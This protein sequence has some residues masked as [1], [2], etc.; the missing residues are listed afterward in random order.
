[1]TPMARLG[2]SGAGGAYPSAMVGPAARVEAAPYML[3]PQR[4]GDRPFRGASQPGQRQ[5]LRL[6]VLLATIVAMVL[7][8]S[9]LGLVSGARAQ[10]EEPAPKRAVV[11]SGPVHSATFRYRQYAAAIADAAEAEGMD[12]HRVFYPNATPSR[13]KRLANGA[14]LFV[15]VGHGNGWPSPYPPFQEATKNGLGLNPEDRDKRTTSKVVYKGAD[16]LKANI[17][18]AP[19]AVV[20]LSHL[21][22]ASG[23]ASSGMAIPS[24]SVAVERVD[25]FAN[26]FLASGARV[27]WALGWQPGADVVRALAREDATMN[28][29]F[30]TRYR[31]GVNPLN[32]WVG[33]APGFYASRRTPGATVHIDPDPAYG[34]LRGLTGDLEFTTREW[35]NAAEAPP[36]DT[37]PP[38][39]RDVGAAQAPVTLA[40][41]DAEPP[42]FT[43]NGDRLS[44]TIAI[45]HRLS[46]NAFV[47]LRISRGDTTVR[48][49]TLWSLKGPG[50]ITWDGR[51]NNGDYVNEG[52]FTVTMTP[53]DRAGNVG[54]PASTQ[55][56]VLN[57]LKAPAAVPPL[58]HAS[59]GDALAPRSVLRAKLTRP[60]TVTWVVRD[61]SGTVVRSGL[62]G[63]EMDA[64]T[65]RFAWDGTDDAGEQLP[66]G[67]YRGRV[68]IVRP[69]GSYG[70][71][72]IVRKMPFWF[73]PS[74]WTLRRGETLSVVVDSAEAVDGRPAISVRAPGRDWV[75]L[76][77]RRVDDDTF[78]SQVKTRKAW[79]PGQLRVR[80]EATDSGGG[81]QATRYVLK[82]R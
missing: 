7:G 23:N 16:W 11:V 62:D 48:R 52:R 28:A 43:P 59:D 58:F 72:V 45:S 14:D 78:R 38:V 73:K 69:Q 80:V 79:R 12:V 20:I 31:S 60:A 63:V 6:A 49:R 67:V 36:P 39:I 15:Y 33:A 21:S 26:G 8:G 68:R 19:N 29:V 34:Y 35:R 81:T 55:V 4:P 61:A 13:V 76:K 42:V 22:Y 64:G 74:R 77:V 9:A 10:D 18:F 65:V 17:R 46:E 53:T 75:P 41:G 82:L 40:T 1:M 2:P 50:S 32:G 54:E 30:M 51:K 47:E 56:T 57:S 66:D 27:V 25:N 44:D 24:R 37:D 71:E 5:L 3:D 70:H